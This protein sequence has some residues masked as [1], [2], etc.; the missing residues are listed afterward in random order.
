DGRLRALLVTGCLA[1]RAGQGLLDEF[2]E[3]DAVLGTG[4]WR[5]V[6]AAARHALGGGVARTAR[7]DYPGGALDS[8]TVRALSTPRHLAY[9]KISEGCDH[10]CTFCI[11]PKLR[12][13]QRSRS[14]EDLV[15]EAERL[16]AHGVKELNLIGQDTTG[17][18]TDLPGRPEL[19]DLLAA[20]DRV[21][22]LTWIR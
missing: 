12:G 16:A 8:L 3:V 1:Q 6:V 15:G 4:Q 22:G 14:L 11:I 21:A 13:K 17:W 7:T 9:L 18:G 10:G 19:A 20:L 5:E 2:P